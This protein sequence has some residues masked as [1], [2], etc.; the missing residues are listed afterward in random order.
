MRYTLEVERSGQPPLHVVCAIRATSSPSGGE[1]RSAISSARDGR[2]RP[3]GRR[4]R[5]ATRAGGAYGLRQRRGQ[6]C[7]ARAPRFS[8][9]SLAATGLILGLLMRSNPTTI[10]IEACF[11][12]VSSG[13]DTRLRPDDDSRQPRGGAPQ[14]L[15]SIFR[16]TTDRAT[17][18]LQSFGLV[19]ADS[20]PRRKRSPW[21]RIRLP[22]M[23]S[24]AGPWC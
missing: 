6:T 4:S 19:Y 20:S 7:A 18:L 5:R 9:F 15:S 1:P 13:S 14:I 21:F 11:L 8:G 23:A 10:P 22:R 24:G 3:A 2:R 12:V 17:R 16:R